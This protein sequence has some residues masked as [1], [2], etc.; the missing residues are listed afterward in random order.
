MNPQMWWFVV[1]ASGIVAWLFLTAAVLWGIALS[2][3]VFAKRRRPAW[4]LDLHRALGALSIGMVAIHLAA[5]VAD[6]YLHFTVVDLVVPFASEWKP[7]QVALGVIAM[8]GLV[9]VETT[10][11][12]MK[13]LPKR[14]WR[15]VHFTSYSTFVL[16]SLHGTFAGTDATNMLYVATSVV[17]TVAVVAAVVYRILTRQAVIRQ[18]ERSRTLDSRS[19]AIHQESQRRSGAFVG[20]G[21]REEILDSSES[22]PRRVHVDVEA[23]TSHGHDRCGT[24]DRS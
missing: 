24:P 16:A 15:G 10:S 3:N 19:H 9:V 1:R 4:L 17:A 21:D 12:A 7:W 11:L 20:F 14:L 6:S 13:H 2:T 5:L 18:R 22:A 23:D 8:W